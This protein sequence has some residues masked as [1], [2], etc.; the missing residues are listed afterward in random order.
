MKFLRNIFGVVIGYLIFA[1]SAVTLFG[2]SGID[3]HVETDVTTTAS[4][5]IFGCVFCF[6]GGYFCKMIADTKTLRS[7]S[8][9]ALLLAGFAAFSFFKSDGSH[10]TQIAAI[11]LFSPMSLLGGF[12][13]Q[14]LEKK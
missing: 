6:I 14:R 12:F 2:F 4:V 1:L 8:A 9:L 3:P 11:F 7:N 5:I 13:R 10:Y